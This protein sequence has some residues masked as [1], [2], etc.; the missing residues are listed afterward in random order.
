MSCL[1]E[2]KSGHYKIKSKLPIVVARS[3][4][5]SRQEAEEQE[6]GCELG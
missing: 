3:C 2:K 5:L 4:N 6:D 1:S